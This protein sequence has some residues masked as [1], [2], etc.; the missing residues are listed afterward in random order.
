MNA[1]NVVCLHFATTG[2]DVVSLSDR[3]LASAWIHC[4]GS[5]TYQSE[6]TDPEP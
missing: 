4:A 5:A 3:R 2:N 6:V 1:A